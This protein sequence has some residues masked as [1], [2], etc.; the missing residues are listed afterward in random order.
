MA[1]VDEATVKVLA[2]KGGDGSVSLHSEPFKPRGGPDG[3]NGGDGGSVVLEV[4]TGVHD[5]GWLA[6]H[7]H[8]RAEP[9]K[10]GR[11]SR[12][13]GASGADLVIPVPDGTVAFDDEGLLADLVGEGSRAVVAEGGR[14][15]RGSAE[16]AGPRNRLPRAAEPGEEGEERRLRI[17]LRTV[18][19]VGLVGLPNA[20]KSTL[21]GRLTA[22]KPKVANYPFTTLSPNLGVAGADDDRFVVADVPG[23][24]EGA[25]RGKGLGHRFLRHVVR[26]RAL[27][28]VVDL[29]MDDPAADLATLRAE[30]KAYDPELAARP[31]VVVGS[32]AD[33]VDDAVAAAGALDTGALPVS[34]MTGEGVD[35]LLD[36]LGLLAREATDAQPAR[37]SYVVLRP[38]RARFTVERDAAGRF[39]LKGRSVERWVMETDLDDD[40]QVALLQQRLRKEGI[41]QHLTKLGARRGDEIEIHGRVFEWVP[42]EEGEVL[43]EAREP[44]EGS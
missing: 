2:G 9:G 10:P 11:S 43:A 4:S 12:R 14:G 1:F 27:V 16:L 39:Q 40:R 38:G 29:A 31:A 17:E 22:A 6:D 18:A 13:H 23:L 28:L 41:T 42:D 33:L 34:A 15:G 21:L 8:Q 5:L 24:I 30:L 44:E 37:T 7:P 32:K 19:D 35:A 26:C 25:H 3:G 20:G 36:R